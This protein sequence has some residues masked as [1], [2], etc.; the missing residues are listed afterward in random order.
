[1]DCPDCGRT[2]A[3]RGWCF[4]CGHDFTKDEATAAERPADRSV[5]RD[6]VDRKFLDAD[7]ETT[8]EEQ[9]EKARDAYRNRLEEL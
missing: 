7:V 3:A 5:E 1:M 2:V 9:R 4:Y 6:E 8:R